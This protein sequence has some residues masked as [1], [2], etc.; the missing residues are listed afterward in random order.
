MKD[1][2]DKKSTLMMI[3]ADEK[4]IHEISCY[5][6]LKA[7]EWYHKGNRELDADVKIFHLSETEEFHLG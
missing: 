5:L 4:A 7:Q 3:I 1:N 2:S 6:K